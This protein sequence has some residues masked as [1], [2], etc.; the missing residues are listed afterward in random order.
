MLEAR[1]VSNLKVVG[2]LLAELLRNGL[3][4]FKQGRIRPG[5]G[6]GSGREGHDLT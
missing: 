1:I 2:L 6:E 4:L 3:F 5:A